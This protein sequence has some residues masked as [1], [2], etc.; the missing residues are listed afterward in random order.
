MANVDQTGYW[1]TPSHQTL[2]IPHITR[3]PKKKKTGKTGR[4]TG[5][6]QFEILKLLAY[7]N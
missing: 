7:L 3:Q 2:M 6:P 1:L 4:P 5:N